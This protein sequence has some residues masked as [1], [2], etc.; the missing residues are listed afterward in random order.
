[1]ETLHQMINANLVCCFA[2]QPLF[3]AP[4]S[5]QDKTQLHWRDKQSIITIEL[6]F[7]MGLSL[8]CQRK[9]QLTK[10]IKGLVPL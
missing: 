2:I 1:M 7:Q 10:L 3:S 5:I 8:T 6:P 4:F 9:M